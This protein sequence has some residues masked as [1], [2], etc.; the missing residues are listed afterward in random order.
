MKLN[1]GVGPRRIVHIFV[2]DGE[3]VDVT[4]H[5]KEYEVSVFN[6]EL[7]GHELTITES[8]PQI[9]QHDMVTVD[10]DIVAMLQ[11]DDQAILL[12]GRDN[13]AKGPKPVDDGSS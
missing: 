4:I 3:T 9:K 12:G 1:V 6:S 10:A 11:D 13:I 7:H 5:N 8:K 2:D